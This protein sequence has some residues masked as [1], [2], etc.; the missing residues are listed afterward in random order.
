M[1]EYEEIDRFPKWAYNKE[2]WSELVA[3]ADKIIGD[4]FYREI[5]PEPIDEVDIFLA[6]L[7]G[8]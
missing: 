3:S 6:S 4:A 2:E 1:I 7:I 5:I 8:S